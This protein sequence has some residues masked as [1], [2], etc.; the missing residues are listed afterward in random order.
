MEPLPKTKKEAQQLSILMICPQYLPIVGGYERAAERLSTA[1]SERSHNIMVITE[2]RKME[3]PAKE[4]IDGVKVCRLWC[5]YRPRLHILTALTSFAL[6]LLIKGRRF[7]VWHVH[8]YGLHAALAVALGK[9]LRRPVVLK[10]TSS[11]NHGLARATKIGRFA[12]LTAVLLKRVTAIVALTQETARE[13]LAFGISPERIHQLGNGVD[14]TTFYPH[15]ELER[16]KLKQMLGIDLHRIVIYVGRFSTEK[17]PDGLL[18][19]W[20]NARPF[21]TEEWKLILVGGGPM[22]DELE[23]TILE[24]GLEGSVT[25]IGQQRNVEQW[26]GAAD[27]YVISSHNE[28]LSNTMLEAM[29]SGLPVIATRVSGVTELVDDSKAGLVAKLGDVDNLAQA[30]VCLANDAL[31]RKSMGSIARQ[32]IEQRYSIEAVAEGHEAMYRHILAKGV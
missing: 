13:A 3:W 20:I 8:Q 26:M 4:T 5:I 24:H 31:L 2:R 32:V 16:N 12:L 6:F 10:L 9:L 29:A 15:N 17:N 27:I 30:L 1:L 23:S 28:G 18:Q 11:A 21:L 22:H 19:A 14:T 7:D 25:I